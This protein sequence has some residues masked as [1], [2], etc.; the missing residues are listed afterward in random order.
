MLS[1]YIIK[2]IRYLS[3]FSRDKIITTFFKFCF[4]ICI[5]VFYKS[6]LRFFWILDQFCS[7][8][9]FPQK[10]R[11]F[12]NR[13]FQRRPHRFHLR[14]SHPRLCLRRTSIAA[15]AALHGNDRLTHLYSRLRD[16]ATIVTALR[17]LTVC[18][19]CRCFTFVPVMPAYFIR[20]VVA[21]L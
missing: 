8:S 9:A 19:P 16:Q 21:R 6:F 5:C 17:L 3:I 20:I 1:T 4:Y 13:A 2:F 15:Y 14:G 7:V 18:N 12:L 11:S 10:F